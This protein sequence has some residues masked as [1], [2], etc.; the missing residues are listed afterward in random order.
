[1]KAARLPMSGAYSYCTI[2]SA[3]SGKEDLLEQAMQRGHFKSGDYDDRLVKK[4]LRTF[5]FKPTFLLLRESQG[6]NSGPL[7]ALLA[8]LA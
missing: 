3:E 5:S 6:G 2:V 7:K 4:H 1:M 8:F